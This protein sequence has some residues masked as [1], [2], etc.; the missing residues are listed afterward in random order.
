M[1]LLAKTHIIALL[2][3]M[4]SL[5]IMTIEKK[6][7]T[8]LDAARKQLA[9][10]Q[11][12]SAML[13]HTK[14]QLLRK[15][16]GKV[17][18]AVLPHVGTATSLAATLL[19]QYYLG[20][21][22]EPGSI[23]GAIASMVSG[24][25]G[26]SIGSYAGARSLEIQLQKKYGDMKNT[27]PDWGNYILTLRNL[28]LQ[29]FAVFDK[30]T[31][32]E[33]DLTLRVWLAKPAVSCEQKNLVDGQKIYDM[34]RAREAL[35]LAT[36]GIKWKLFLAYWLDEYRKKYLDEQYGDFRRNFFGDL[37]EKLPEDR[38]EECLTTSWELCDNQQI[39]NAINNILN[40]TK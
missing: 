22:F 34:V 23:K 20:K 9:I 36:P 38:P 27:S 10:S 3:L 11:K 35:K 21:H 25:I 4:M 5:S 15:Y 6:S 14:L 31:V 39:R 29:P 40:Q 37:Q 32:A 16:S 2:L 13:T 8:D 28:G 12:Q 24:S 7:A 1:K 33:I 26:G 30:K 19:A 18:M 17:G